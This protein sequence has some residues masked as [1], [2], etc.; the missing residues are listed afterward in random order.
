MVR[1]RAR[2]PYH[3]GRGRFREIRKFRAIFAPRAP[4]D[5]GV[6]D[7]KLG[8]AGFLHI[9]DLRRYRQLRQ[10]LQILPDSRA[11]ATCISPD[12]VS[13]SQERGR[14]VFPS[15]L[16]ACVGHV[17]SSGLPEASIRV[18]TGRD[19]DPGFFNQSVESVAGETDNAFRHGES[20]PR[21]ALR[22][23]VG[24]AEGAV[25]VH[26]D[27][28]IKCFFL[29]SHP[30]CG[31]DKGLGGKEDGETE[32]MGGQGWFVV[33]IWL[34]GDWQSIGRYISRYTR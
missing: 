20:V 12:G 10:G 16:R 31:A 14:D 13:F 33:P 1:I 29:A 32:S 17:T 25:E 9:F 22:D 2:A 26:V 3:S 18:L 4:G 7:A 34:D 21:V 15:L 23:V 30:I 19:D 27:L 6:E 8:S 11:I 24:A 28:D 5:D